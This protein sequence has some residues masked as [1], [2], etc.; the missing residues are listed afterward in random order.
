MLI[1]SCHQKQSCE[2]HD[3]IAL[4]I[5]LVGTAHVSRDSAD[6]V[7]ELIHV[8]RPSTIMVELCKKRAD[9]LRSS[10]KV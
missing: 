4:Q 9:K 8:V 7:R 1:C 3:V 5:F 2:S 10:P 6:E